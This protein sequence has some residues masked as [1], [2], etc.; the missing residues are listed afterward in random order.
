MHLRR[1]MKWNEVAWGSTQ[2]LPRR[3]KVIADFWRTR[4]ILTLFDWC[5]PK[6]LGVRFVILGYRF[7]SNISFGRILLTFLALLPTQALQRGNSVDPGQSKSDYF[8]VMP[9]SDNLKLFP[10]SSRSDTVDFGWYCVIGPLYLV[11]C[12]NHRHIMRLLLYALWL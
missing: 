11:C 5:Y 12:N 3:L 4:Q 1:D 9:L 7:V 10:K 8:S 2:T 6:I